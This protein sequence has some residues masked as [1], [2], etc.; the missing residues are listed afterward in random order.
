MK[1]RRI[2]VWDYNGVSIG[3]GHNG[4]ALEQPIKFEVDAWCL[5]GETG[6]IAYFIL[7]DILYEAHGDDGH[8]WLSNTMSIHWLPEL[9]KVVQSIEPID[10]NEGDNYHV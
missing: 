9:K 3:K 7:E 4:P 5:A 2:T 8:W 1:T 10:K 6:F